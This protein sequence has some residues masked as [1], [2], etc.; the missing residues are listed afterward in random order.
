MKNYR[1]MADDVFRRID[2]YET[3][4]K[5]KGKTAA[6]IAVIAAVLCT[7]SIT[8]F[9]LSEGGQYLIKQINGYFHYS[10]ENHYSGD[11][12]NGLT[13]GYVPEHFEKK[14]YDT[15]NSKMITYFYDNTAYVYAAMLDENGN[16]K[17]E[18]IENPDL[19]TWEDFEENRWFD[20]TKLT[21][22]TI[23]SFVEDSYSIQE[24]KAGERTYLFYSVTE[25]ERR[26]VWN[27][28]DYIYR[29]RGDITKDEM[30][31]IAEHVQ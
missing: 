7:L 21:S 25:A 14:D 30:L 31:E 18:V 19:Y 22:D 27:E 11:I 8:V 3:A 24:I 9:A 4:K 15:E 20:V 10:V 26:L 23:Y 29:I 5:K 12:D 1:E 17:E 28:G 13:V 2:E 6:K 16:I